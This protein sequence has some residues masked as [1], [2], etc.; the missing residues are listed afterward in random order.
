MF[1][2]CK[3][4][5]TSDSTQLHFYSPLSGVVRNPYDL[6]TSLLLEGMP[7]DCLT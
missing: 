4:R 6:K 2:A 1:V 3:G 7:L 5:S